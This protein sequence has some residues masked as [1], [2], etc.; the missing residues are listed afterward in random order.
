[1]IFMESENRL[2]KR[3][4]HRINEENTLSENIKIRIAEDE[5]ENLKRLAESNHM[6]V[7]QYIRRLVKQEIE[8]SKKYGLV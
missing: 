6:S 5:K 1:M 2:K 3:G 4:R 8:T 7:S